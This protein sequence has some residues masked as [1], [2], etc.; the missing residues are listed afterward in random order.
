MDVASGALGAAVKF[1]LIILILLIG[2]YSIAVIK[3]L[4]DD[5]LNKKKKWI[6]GLITPFSI[7]AGL[8]I[9]NLT[10]DGDINGLIVIGLVILN[11]VYLSKPIIEY[12]SRLMYDGNSTIIKKLLF[13]FLSII[14][15]SVEMVGIFAIIILI[16]KK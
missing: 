14:I 6:F 15:S 1:F 5:N 9:S 13:G 8:I 7:A 4:M 10:G 11:L 2:I 12:F 3:L 16:M